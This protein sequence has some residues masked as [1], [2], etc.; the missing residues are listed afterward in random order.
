MKKVLDSL[1]YSFLIV[2]ELQQSQTEVERGV[3]LSHSFLPVIFFPGTPF[4]KIAEVAGL[5]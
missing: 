3:P 1:P 4:N 5:N 2:E